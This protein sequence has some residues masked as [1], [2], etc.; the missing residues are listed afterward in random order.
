M[1][2][3][4]I[5]QAQAG[6]TNPDGTPFTRDQLASA[7]QAATVQSPAVTANPT[8]ASGTVGAITPESL[9]PAT[10]VTLPQST[11]DS[12]SSDNVVAT[13]SGATKSLAQYIS[14]ATPPTTTTDTTYQGIL[15]S[16]A[17]LT[18]ND[19]NKSTD[20]AA[21]NTAAGVDTY[22]QQ[23]SDLNGKVAIGNA[24]YAQ[25][26]GQSA[27][28]QAANETQGIGSG[29]PA[30]FYQGINAA[31]SRQFNTQLAS[32]AAEVG[33]YAAQAQA[34][35]GN[36]TTALAIAQN[37][38]DAKYAPIEDSIKVK[39]AQLAALQPLMDKEQA[40]Q[41]TA[42]QRQYADQ[43]QATADA[44][45][46]AQQNT[47]LALTAGI[48]TKFVNHNGEFF[49]TVTGETYSNPA[50]FFKAAGVT[51]F[52]QAYQQGLVS[53]LSNARISDINTVQQMIAKYPDAGIKASDSLDAAT[54][55]LKNSASYRKDTYIAPNAYSGGGGG[56]YTP[57]ADPQVDAYVTAVKNGNATLTN[58][59]AGIRGLVAQGLS[60]GSTIVDSNTD[61]AVQ[62]I[63]ASHPGEY[64]QAADAIDA[65]FG[66]GTA[67]KYDAQLK[68]VY[69]QGQ[70]PA[71]AF[72]STTYSPL[73][74]SRLATV[75]NKITA[76]VRDLPI[77]QA[78]SQAQVYL[79]R[80]NSAI[81]NPGSIG[82]AELLDSIVKLN[83]GGNA[84]TDSQVN[85][86]TG[87]GSY[88]DKLDVLKNQVSKKGGAL[89][90]QQRQELY[91]IAK[92]TVSGYQKAWQPVYDQTVAQLNA[93]GIPPQFNTL[94]NLNAIAAEAAANSAPAN[95]SSSAIPKG[96]DGAAYGYP[97]Y[98]SD[99]T[100]WV[101]K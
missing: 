27:A 82:D 16:I 17:Q 67:T 57:G 23:L 4:T 18:S 72:S 91:S 70:D 22:K 41:A 87:Y 11:Q 64:G 5:Q 68:A 26:Q 29:T 84:I 56:V 101:P 66:K 76:P 25:L 39:Q 30:V 71:T 78:A 19:A 97:G 31:I 74:A 54:A 63:I 55:K 99:G 79:P 7:A 43:Q 32:K 34:A 44:K 95:N 8:G 3:L 96:T 92:Q 15:D 81:A 38:I 48:T 58:V 80:I 90:D 14:D 37:A 69:N 33:M 52:D 50:D 40:V 9:Q 47:S 6:Q 59:P 60:Q 65:T 20:T 93:A 46:K 49:N 85:L 42:L 89:S 98:V 36:L 24:E 21:A 53:D 35:S 1:D 86:I 12:S 83:T 77:Y 62:A 45:A 88:S 51:S 2:G 73:A 75:S 13:A 28:A 10:P 61:Q 94:P 100:Q